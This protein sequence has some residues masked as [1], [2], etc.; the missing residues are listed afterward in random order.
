YDALISRRIYK[1]A[2]SHEKTRGIILRGKGAHFDP[3]IVDA[4]VT[5]EENFKQIATQYADE[6]TEQ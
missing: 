2:F 6:N 1:E 4:F 3:D 5:A